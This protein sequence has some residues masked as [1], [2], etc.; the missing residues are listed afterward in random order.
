MAYELGS[1]GQCNF[2]NQI[3]KLILEKYGIPMPASGL[4]EQLKSASKIDNIEWIE[5]F[6]ELGEQILIEH[7]DKNEAFRYRKL[8]RN[9]ILKLTQNGNIEEV[10]LSYYQIERQVKEWK[11]INLDNDEIDQIQNIMNSLSADSNQIT[12]M[13][14][15]D[16]K[17]EIFKLE[18]IIKSKK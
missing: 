7:S 5:L 6:K 11:G 3:S 9:K 8:L 16:L 1:Q 17:K 2:R 13:I 4:V 10:L 18:Q 15:D 12:T 14:N